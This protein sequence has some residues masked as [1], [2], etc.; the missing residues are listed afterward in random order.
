MQKEYIMIGADFAPIE[1]DGERIVQGKQEEVLDPQVAEL[2]RWA[3]FSVFNMEAPMEYKDMIP[4]K[5]DGPRLYIPTGAEILYQQLGVDLLLLANN[6]IMDWS[7]EGLFHT[8]ERLKGMGIAYIGAG[9]DQDSAD[10]VYY[11][12]ISGK[13][14]GFYA[15][16]EKEFSIADAGKAGANGY[17]P[18]ITAGRIQEIKKQCDFLIV[19]YHG[20]R[21]LYQYPSPDQQARCRDM[22]DH[23]ADL[24]ICQHSHCIGAFEHYKNSDIFYGQGNFVF[25]EPDAEVCEHSILLKIYPG[26]RL[27]IET[28]PVRRKDHQVQLP[29]NKESTVILKEFEKL[30]HDITNKNFVEDNYRA[31]ARDAIAPYLYQFAGWPLWAIRMDKL[32]GRRLIKRS[33]RKNERRLLYLQNVLQCD[34]HREIV[35]EGLK[36][37]RMQGSSIE[38]EQQ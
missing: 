8:M 32:F 34:A 33:F 4:L 21:E 11:R 20:G 22:A 17:I 14:L 12:E 18:G 28:V 6:H 7:K 9:K 26:E 38:K 23:G 15:V 31:L 1:N 5:K 16:A 10:Q 13:T 25:G 24:V 30:N 35:L 37:L 3:A 2:I 19:F 27:A 36:Q 29:D